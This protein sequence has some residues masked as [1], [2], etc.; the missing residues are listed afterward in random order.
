MIGDF[1]TKIKRVGTGLGIHILDR[2]LTAF[3]Q[4]RRHIPMVTAHKKDKFFI[5]DD[6]TKFSNLGWENLGV[7]FRER[8]FM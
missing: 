8:L 5:E 4:T 2:D 3:I 7:I 6:V 1:L